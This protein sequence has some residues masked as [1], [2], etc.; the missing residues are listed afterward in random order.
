MGIH[1]LE[2]VGE[3]VQLWICVC[4]QVCLYMCVSVCILTAH[5][6]SPQ[7]GQLLLQPPLPG[8]SEV[9][10]WAFQGSRSPGAPPAFSES[11][12]WRQPC[13]APGARGT[14]QG[15][16]SP[17]FC[18]SLAN[19][20]TKSARE[21]GLRQ[22]GKGDRIRRPQLIPMEPPTQWN[23]CPVLVPHHFPVTVQGGQAGYKTWVKWL[24]AR[25]GALTPGLVSQR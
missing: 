21:V 15:P 12:G 25:P 16:L 18:H 10:A 22:G 3:Y 4:I 23:P 8:A 24:W 9:P 20:Q 11:A 7:A 14:A 19:D 5:E 6:A 17:D 2:Y 1:K 13:H